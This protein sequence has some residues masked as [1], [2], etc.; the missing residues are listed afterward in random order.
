[1]SLN[2][3]NVSVEVMDA[4][5]LFSLAGFLMIFPVVLAHQL[6]LFKNF[7]PRAL[8]VAFMRSLIFISMR[9]TAFLYFDEKKNLI[10]LNLCVTR[11]KSLFG[12]WF[13]VH[14][15][16]KSKMIWFHA[17]ALAIR[18]SIERK[19]Q[20]GLQFVDLGPSR[21]ESSAQNKSRVGCL[22]MHDW[23]E[24]CSQ[25]VDTLSKFHELDIE[26]CQKCINELSLN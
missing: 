26:T 10:G 7:Y 9:G 11:A 8:P 24:K 14:P 25:A 5:R 1:V 22:E 13:Y 12:V 2:R 16:H 20:D 19:K 3:A 4:S 17:A 21:T 23:R 6:A 15:E 18:Y